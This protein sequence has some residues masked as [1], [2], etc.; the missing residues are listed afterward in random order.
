MMFFKR[1]VTPNNLSKVIKNPPAPPSFFKQ[2]DWSLVK[3]SEGQQLS[4]S[5]QTIVKELENTS[6]SDAPGPLLKN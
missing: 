3:K 6:A 4:K 5:V 1:F 2:M